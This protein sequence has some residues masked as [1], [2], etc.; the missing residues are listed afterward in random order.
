MATRVNVKFPNEISGLLAWW[1]AKDFDSLS[2]GTSITT[3]NDKSGNG[4]NFTYNPPASPL[5]FAASTKQ[6]DSKGNSVVSGSG[7]YDCTI[8]LSNS[9]GF[10]F[11]NV[12][13]KRSAIYECVFSSFE[14]NN[15][16]LLI[17]N[18]FMA[19]S[20]SSPVGGQDDITNTFQLTVRASTVAAQRL[21]KQNGINYT[22]SQNTFSLTGLFLNWRGTFGNYGINDHSEMIIF[23][24]LLSDNEVMLMERY[25]KFKW[26]L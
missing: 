13:R 26:G 6:L 23:N 16:F 1:D 24:R 22:Q 8:S 4:N 14:G 10:T 2:A 11:F 20:A 21:V 19:N 5:N 15:N 17:D 18:N 12:Y 3:W 9:A 25:L 7:K